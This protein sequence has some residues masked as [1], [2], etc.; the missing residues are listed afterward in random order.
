[1]PELNDF[2]L[3]FLERFFGPMSRPTVRAI[4]DAHSRPSGRRQIA[5]VQIV[6]LAK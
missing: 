1:M 6:V 3:F 4:T 5:S 2:A